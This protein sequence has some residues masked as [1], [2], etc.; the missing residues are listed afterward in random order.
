MC[1]SHTLINSE[2]KS[3]MKLPA[4]Y[5]MAVY[6]KIKTAQSWTKYVNLFCSSD[7]KPDAINLSPERFMFST[8]CSLLFQECKMS[9]ADSSLPSIIQ[10]CDM[11]SI[12]FIFVKRNNCYLNVSKL[13]TQ[14]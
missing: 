14:F 9:L 13:E 4:E 1:L 5:L 11:I 7:Q 8:L 6:L 2:N 12:V 3:C 10:I